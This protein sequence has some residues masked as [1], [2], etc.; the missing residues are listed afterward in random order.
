MNSL[1][2]TLDIYLIKKAPSL[3]V[4]IKEILVQFAPW[5]TIITVIASLPV[6]LGIFG[7]GAMFYSL[8]FA[9]Y[10][11]AAGFNYTLAVIFLGISV[12]M[13]ALAVPGLLARSKSGWNM[14]FYATIVNAVYQ[15]INF[16]IIGM[17]IG[18][19]ITL[20]LLFQVKEYYK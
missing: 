16:E 17:V 3:P 20:Y 2:S 19:L 10:A 8:P 5:I 9:G 12:V 11:A 13:R 4:N 6:I 7:L 18:T 14:L 1:I 15:I